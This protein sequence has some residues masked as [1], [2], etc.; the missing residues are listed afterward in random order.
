MFLKRLAYTNTV[1]NYERDKELVRIAANVYVKGLINEEQ[2]KKRV[3][4]ICNKYTFRYKRKLKEIARK[5]LKVK[6]QQ[7]NHESI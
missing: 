1:G 3:D 6:R 7:F 5:S 4:N 2:Y